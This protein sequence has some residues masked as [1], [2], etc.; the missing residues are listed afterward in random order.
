MQSKTKTYSM[1]T[2]EY[3][4]VT[5]ANGE[6]TIMRAENRDWY[7]AHGAKIEEANAEEIT[8][9][10]PEEREKARQASTLEDENAALKARIAELEAELAA[11]KI[12][13]TTKNK[14]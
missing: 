6:T 11:A 12:S 5:T 1:N 9:F 4:K 8:E 10:Y 3:I 13:K 2:K 14:K 7:I